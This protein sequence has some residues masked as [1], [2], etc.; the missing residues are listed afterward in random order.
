MSYK[1]GKGGI[2]EGSTKDTMVLVLVLNHRKMKD[3]H[4][5]GSS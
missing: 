1:K 4:D 5:N 2:Q 3:L